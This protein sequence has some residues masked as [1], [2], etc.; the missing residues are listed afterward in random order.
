MGQPD[1]RQPKSLQA[2]TR[3]ELA[4]VLAC[5]CLLGLIVLPMLGR[6]RAAGSEAV[7]M[8]NL[9]NLG[10]A[11]LVY[12]DQNRG[13]VPEEGSIGFTVF[14]VNNADA[15]YNL[16][17]LPEYPAMRTLYL[18]N[19]YPLPA[20]GSVYSCPA[21]PLPPAGQPSVAWAYFMYAE[22][23]RACVNKSGTTPRT[24]QT[25]IPSVPR[26]S[27]TFLMAEVDDNYVTNSTIP[28]NS[29]VLAQYTAVRH[30]GFS[31]FTMM[32]GSVRLF[33]TND[34][35]HDV[36]TAQHEWYVN[37]TD[38]SGGYTSWNCYWWPTPTTP[39]SSP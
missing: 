27:S 37:G 3:L 23:A 4:V 29:T 2:F 24:Y 36:V 17:V 11:L 39:T 32:D 28:A 33:G 19:S 7:C 12:S 34:F 35:L 22:N 10:R 21:A 8:N 31:V 16:A 5:V 15:W 26:P 9:R 38:A 13:F 30:D 14:H 25:R 1:K 6:S 18:T 20:S